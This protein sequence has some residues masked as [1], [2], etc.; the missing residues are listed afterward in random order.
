M[1]LKKKIFI[2]LILLFLSVVLRGF[3]TI[4]DGYWFDE[5]LSFYISDPNIDFDKFNFRH[6]NIIGGAEHN[7]I[8]YFYFLREFFNIFGYSSEN[9]RIFTILFGSLSVLVAFF[10]YSIFAE[11]KKTNYLICF[12][13]FNIFLIWQSKE[14]RPATIVLFISIINY[15]YFLFY[16][17]NSNNF[18]TLI[19]IF[20][21]CLILSLYPFTIVILI[22]QFIT[23]F[24]LAEDKRIRSF[25]ILF[26]SIFSYLLLNYDYI[27][28]KLNSTSSHWGNLD[29]K[30]FLNF[31]Y[32]TF[33]GS[34]FLGGLSLII[35]FFAFLDFIKKKK[36][37]NIFLF[38]NFTLIIVSY[39]FIII[40]SSIISGI[41]VPR[42]FIF[43][44]PSIIFINVDFLWRKKRIFLNFYL[45]LTIINTL[46]LYNDF[47]IPK[48][49]IYELVNT[50]DDKSKY[51]YLSTKKPL[52]KNFIINNNYISSR[53]KF[54]NNLDQTTNFWYVCLNN[55]RYA[56]GNNRNLPDEKSC[57]IT[58]NNYKLVNVV[59]I[60]D[61][62]LSL[63]QKK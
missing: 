5:T 28:T 1:I 48:P 2:I 18:N 32:R 47:K 23:C 33:F 60:N 34:I 37:K 62:K 9:G 58:L 24:Y 59:K 16:L 55:P 22:T 38:F 40:Y 36:Y 44:I 30:F 63:F 56:V 29:Y 45:I 15:S 10:Y 46:V 25:I 57:E 8:L 21:N 41:A 12:V 19:L 54:I 49:P 31:F 14:V 4:S 53:Y 61:F 52:F 13:I 39:L 20:L 42:Y 3:N 27:F 43:I 6:K 26:F 11:P 17:K 7:P 35:S 51:L 50:L